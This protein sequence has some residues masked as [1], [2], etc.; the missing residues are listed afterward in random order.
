VRVSGMRLVWT[1]HNVLPIGERFTDDVVA[2]RRL[3]DASDL[4]ISHSRATLAELAEL[5]IVP[6]KS[7][8]IPHGPYEVTQ[9]LGQLRSPAATP[10]PR[11]FLF[12]GMIEEYKGIDTLLTAFAQL[13]P[14]LDAELLIAGECRDPSL[15]ASLSAL[16][17]RSTLPVSLRFERIA[18]AEVS[19]LLENADVMVLPYRQSSTSGSALLALTYGRPL[20]VPDLPGLAELPDEA[21]VRYDRTADGLAGALADLIRADAD[22]LAKMSSAGYAYCASL[23][24]ESI[25]RK[26]FEEMRLTL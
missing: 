26:T 4:V 5:R 21:A 17:R 25:A 10:G 8:V 22:V 14:G 3:V 2:R 18:E 7:V 19:S 16:G 24:W 13:P 1:A 23:S 20:I 12:F 9:E 11:K 6:R 15:K